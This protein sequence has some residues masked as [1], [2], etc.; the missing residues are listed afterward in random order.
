MNKKPRR[1]GRPHSGN[2]P[3]LFNL[4]PYTDEK[5]NEIAKAEGRTRS[6]V[7][8]QAILIYRSLHFHPK[9][10]RNLKKIRKQ[11]SDF[12]LQLADLRNREKG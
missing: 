10:D 7:V 12:V 3:F 4:D 5:I 9:T 6:E 1:V 8:A 2:R 11:A